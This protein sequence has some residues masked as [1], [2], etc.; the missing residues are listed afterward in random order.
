MPARFGRAKLRHAE[1]EPV[2]GEWRLILINMSCF[3]CGHEISQDAR[4]CDVCGAP[5]TGTRDG[6]LG[7]VKASLLSGNNYVSGLRRFWWLLVLG[8]GIATIAAVMSVYRI[9]FF[10][11]PPSFERKAETT[12]TAYSRLLVTNDQAPY[13]RTRVDNEV[14]GPDG[15]VSVYSNSPDISTLITAANLYPI[16]IASDEVLKLRSEMAGPLPGSITSRAIYEVSSPSRFELSQVPVVEVYGHADTGANA[17]EITKATVAAFLVY[18]NDLQDDAAL[19]RRDRIL[20]QELQAPDGAVASGGTSL[21]LPLMLFLLIVAAFVALAILLDRL[22]P[23]GLLPAGISLP[24]LRRGAAAPVEEPEL[25]EA[26]SAAEPERHAQT[27][28]RV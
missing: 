23:A 16:L 24:G 4:F 25:G 14:T 1:L 9:D 22:F 5:Q 12:Y 11:I 27:R 13:L 2:P 15:S 26:A 18:V 7:V 28:S 8:V 3:N 20:I 17:V 6:P 19:S 10:S 21:S